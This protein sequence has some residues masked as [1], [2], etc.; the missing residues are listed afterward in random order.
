MTL[1]Q[2]LNFILE[3]GKVIAR[4]WAELWSD[5]I[6]VLNIRI[7]LDAENKSRILEVRDNDTGTLGIYFL[8]YQN[9]GRMHF[10]FL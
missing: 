9:I 8:M 4:F 10:F 7:Y 1:A 2:G 3:Q 6:Y 5:M